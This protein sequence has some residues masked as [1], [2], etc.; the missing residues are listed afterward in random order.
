MK[1]VVWIEK[2]GQEHKELV[3]KKCAHL[4]EMAQMGLRVPSGFAL[5]VN[6]YK[7]FMRLS[8]AGEEIEKHLAGI[9]LRPENLGAF[10]DVSRVLRGIVESKKIPDELEDSILSHYRELN[11]RL[12]MRDVAVSVRSA[13]AVSHPGQYETCLN[14]K[15]EKDLLEKVKKVWSSTFNM[16]SLTSRSRHG[17]PLGS[18]PIG[19]AV[20]KMVNAKAA[21]VLFTVDPNNGNASRMII[22]ANWGL[23]ESVVSGNARPDFL[24]LD[25]ATLKPVEK[26]LGT[27][28]SY[29]GFGALG[30]KEVETPVDMRRQLCISDEEAAE[31]GRLGK[32]LEEH[33]NVPQDC[34]WAI[35]Q[36]L[37]FPMNILLL[38]T[39]AEVVAK[40]KDPVD[41]VLDMMLSRMGT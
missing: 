13:G 12:G 38:Q 16:V 11:E 15:G 26:T 30:T 34:E 41:K 4:G 28:E 29:I 10:K 3:G 23:G 2:L 33:F 39:R 17:L 32:V 20:L 18:D 37:V 35:D 5:S 7:D 14:V 27:K 24:V 40:Q 19:V 8:G 22:E 36:D 1:G 25:K 9:D 31:L 6:A 21:G